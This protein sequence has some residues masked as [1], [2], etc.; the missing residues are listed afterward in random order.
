MREL[1]T[2]RSVTSP[3]VRK[4]LDA[5]GRAR[6]LQAAPG[7]AVRGFVAGVALVALALALQQMLV[8]ML[9]LP[10]P[11]LADRL[12]LLPLPAFP[13][14]G[15]AL[16]AALRRPPAER[17]A[18]D[19]DARLELAERVSTALEIEGRP[20]QPGARSDPLSLLSLQ[21]ADALTQL[22]RFEPSEV[23]PAR[24]ARRELLALGVGLVVL[25]VLAALPDPSGA[26]DRRARA[27]EAVRSEAERLSAL[28]EEL[29]AEDPSAEKQALAQALTQV[30]EQLE[31]EAESPERALAALSQAERELA[32]QE[33]TSAAD[34]ELAL[35]RLADALGQA[36]AGRELARRIDQRDYAGAAQELGRLGREASQLDPERQRAL[37]EAL[38]R[39]ATGASRLDPALSDRL[40]DAAAALG[41]EQSESAAE[42]AGQEVRRAGSQAQR[43]RMLERALAA[44]QDSRQA[45]GRAESGGSGQAQSQRASGSPGGRGSGDGGGAGRSQGAQGADGGEPDAGA[46]GAGAGGGERGVDEGEGGGSSAGTGSVRNRGESEPGDFRSRQVSV[47]SSDFEQP[48]VSAGQQTEEGPVGEATVDYRQVLPQYSER[49]TEAMAQRYVPPALKDLVRDYFSSLDGR[50]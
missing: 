37:A 49:A 10:R 36:E 38:Q 2:A 16:A 14:V 15:A 24:L 47:P 29:A 32:R 41:G 33:Q 48:Q 19:A 20:V 12:W 34:A 25:L 43:Q 39:A 42:Q 18:R 8:W 40:R 23:F 45:I 31:R 9:A 7:W 11:F 46:N 6:A 22:R 27:T 4:A 30:A 21:R 1:A 26:G 13:A 44:L 5:F 50:R 35:A 17:I 28:A 3:E